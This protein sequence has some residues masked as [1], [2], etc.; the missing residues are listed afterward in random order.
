MRFT[1]TVSW[2][3]FGI[4]CWWFSVKK[5]AHFHYNFIL[6]RQ[7]GQIPMFTIQDSIVD[8]L[9]N[10]NGTPGQEIYQFYYLSH[11][12]LA[13]FQ[14]FRPSV[15]SR[16]LLPSPSVI[17]CV[18]VVECKRD[19]DNREHGKTYRIL[20]SIAVLSSRSST[21]PALSLRGD[22]LE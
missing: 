4:P 21:K 3:A 22:S 17:P 19:V 16:H 9:N 10:R 6:I 18:C 20:Q 14:S 7:F 15:L 2:I 12:L 13:A 1:W 11:L 8:C 5:Y